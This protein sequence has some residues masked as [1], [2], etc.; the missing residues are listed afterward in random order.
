MVEAVRRDSRQRELRLVSILNETCS[1]A[2]R[3]SGLTDR[4]PNPVVGRLREGEMGSSRPGR[5]GSSASVGSDDRRQDPN[6][7][8]LKHGG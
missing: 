5:S 4:P 6:R 2:P 8:P 1:A 3:D 7:R